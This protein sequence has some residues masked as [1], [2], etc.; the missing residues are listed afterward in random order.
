MAQHNA[1]GTDSDADTQTAHTLIFNLL[2]PA[3]LGLQLMQGLQEAP[4][5]SVVAMGNEG[6]KGEV[7]GELFGLLR[8]HSTACCDI[9]ATDSSHGRHSWRKRKKPVYVPVCGCS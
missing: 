9:K 2:T 4:Y 1:A 5:L 3:P 8:Q 6:L 7:E